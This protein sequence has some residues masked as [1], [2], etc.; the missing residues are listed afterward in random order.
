MSFRTVDAAMLWNSHPGYFF[1]N[2]YFHRFHLKKD[3]A[4]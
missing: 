1:K 2:G 3:T 4:Y